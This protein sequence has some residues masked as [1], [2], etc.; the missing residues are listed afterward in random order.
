MELRTVIIDDEEKA[1]EVLR[2]MLV[3]FCRGVEVVGEANN[4]LSGLKLI[5]QARPD[6]VF[7]DVEMPGGT[8]FEMLETLGGGNFF[9]VFTTAY[10]QYTIPA[11]R[12]GATDYL[13][14]PINMDE[15][16]EAVERVKGKMHEKLALELPYEQYKVQITQQSGTMFVPCAEIICVEGEGRYS[17]LHTTGGK[18]YMVSR[19]LKE[20]EEELGA[21]R[22]FRVHKSFLVNCHHVLRIS[23]ADGGFAE[24]SDGRQIEISRRK[25]TEFQEFM[26]K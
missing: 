10:A 26:K 24:M 20:F 1:I 8:G 7:L 11:I 9:I 22:F 16:R 6:L 5:Q 19:N 17:T 23:H 21:Y 15:L 14:K 12:A 3:Q 2:G 4:A 18:K 25:K 13:L